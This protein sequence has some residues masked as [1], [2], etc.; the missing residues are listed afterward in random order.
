MKLL[1]VSDIHGRYE[2]LIELMDMHKDADALIFLGDGLADL[3]RADA[4]S[5]PFTVF[6]VR[7]NCD[8]QLFPWR[9]DAPVEMT[10]NF[11]GFKLLLLHGQSRNVKSGL[12][13]A[14]LAAKA[15]G[16]NVLLYG[17][18]HVPQEK[19]LPGGT[20]ITSTVSI[21][22]LHILNP[23]SLGAS[24]DGKAHFGLIEIRNGQLL[25]SLGV[26]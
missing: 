2:R 17:H 14:L 20:M 23:G 22:P 11:E 21:G 8:A 7:G 1:V 13:D 15:N 26:L 24:S 6:T 25:T 19:Y 5:Y 12:D 16:A 9:N 3:M 18:T 10:L 4:Y